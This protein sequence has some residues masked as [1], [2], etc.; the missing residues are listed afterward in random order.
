MS[1]APN[2]N[3]K[4]PGKCARMRIPPRREI[5][6]ISLCLN[7]NK[8]GR[9][10]I[11]GPEIV[12]FKKYK[13]PSD[14]SFHAGEGTKNLRLRCYMDYPGNNRLLFIIPPGEK[15]N[16]IKFSLSRTYSSET[17][18]VSRV[19]VLISHSTDIPLVDIHIGGGK[20]PEDDE[21][22]SS[23]FGPGDELAEEEES[24]EN[25]DQDAERDEDDE[26]DAESGDGE[27]S[28]K[29][30]SDRKYALRKSSSRKTGETKAKVS[31]T[32][33]EWKGWEEEEVE[34]FLEAKRSGMSIGAIQRK[35]FPKRTVKACESKLGRLKEQG[36]FVQDQSDED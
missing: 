19:G 26:E 33:T 1:R 5:T 23:F 22:T 28:E 9:I 31:Q 2:T 12:R 3:L 10:T 24:D 21:Q 11:C 25:E 6:K 8:N 30:P 36:K 27:E 14:P 18:D 34:L 17:N 13:K 4:D 35:H 32:G 16:V 29:G 15:P 7:V 20:P